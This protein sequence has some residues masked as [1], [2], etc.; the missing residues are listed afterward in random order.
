MKEIDR[1]LHEAIHQHMLSISP[2]Q[3]FSPRVTLFDR[4]EKALN[5]TISGKVL[6]IGCGNGYASIW[7][8]K[9][10]NVEKVYAMEASKSAVDELL[11]RNISYHK[12][13]DTVI[14]MEGSFSAIPFT[15][16]I[17]YVI[18]FGALHHSPCL[19]STMQSVSRCLKDGGYLIAQEPV[20][21]N[22]TSNQQYIDKYNLIENRFGFDIRNGDR[23]DHFFREAEYITAA[24]F[25]GLDLVLYDDFTPN[26][27][28]EKLALKMF[29]KTYFHIKKDGILTLL[30]KIIKKLKKQNNSGN[31]TASVEVSSER[32][33]TK[34]VKPKVFV[35]QKR[36]TE[37]IPH[38]WY[39]LRLKD[40]E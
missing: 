8:G 9:H 24:A 18:S 27:Q 32:N 33:Y 25:S 11:P 2:D 39:P 29:K 34:N 23:D 13:S 4:I 21:P 1:K 7:L 30:A 10:R 5:L 31:T 17:D 22:T 38:L 35:F 40:D 36:V 28:S 20:M 3:I 6:D 14:P 12:V 15:D 26:A 16:E 19:L 37:Y